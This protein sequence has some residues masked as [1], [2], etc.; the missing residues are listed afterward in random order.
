MCISFTVNYM[1]WTKHCCEEKG[2]TDP[3]C[4]SIE[5]PEDDP[6]HRFTGERCIN[7]TKPWTFQFTGCTKNNTKPERVRVFIK[8]FK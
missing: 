2:K 7:M 5:I 3:Q 1:Y 8:I 6:V 4:A